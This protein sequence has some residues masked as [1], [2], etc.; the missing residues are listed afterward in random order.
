MWQ[1]EYL[2]KFIEQQPQILRLTTPNWKTFGAPF[3][4]DDGAFMVGGTTL[5]L[6]GQLHGSGSGVL[7]DACQFCCQAHHAGPDPEAER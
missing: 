1:V 6:S 7:G 4:Q 2:Q 5:D 3:A